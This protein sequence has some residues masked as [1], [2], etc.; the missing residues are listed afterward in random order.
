MSVCQCIGTSVY[1]YIGGVRVS[2]YWS[3]YRYIDVPI[4][5]CI[6][7]YI[8]VWT[9]YWIY[10]FLA[11]LISWFLWFNGFKGSLKGDPCSRRSWRILLYSELLLGSVK[12]KKFLMVFSIAFQ[13]PAWKRFWWQLGPNLPRSLAIKSIPNRPRRGANPKPICIM[14]SMPSLIDFGTL[15]VE[16]WRV[17]RF[18]K[19]K[20]WSRIDHTASCWQVGWNR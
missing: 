16:F 13:K 10:D 8:D 5:W 11:S 9:Q 15:L 12:G 20:I 6:Y 1:R 18:K 19:K 4:Y 2:R 7:I 17:L 3:I 14:V